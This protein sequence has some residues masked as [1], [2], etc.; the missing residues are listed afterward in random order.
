VSATEPRK[1]LTH[2]HRLSQGQS[3]KC[4]STR[5]HNRGSLGKCLCDLL[6]CIGIMICLS[7]IC[8]LWFGR[9]SQV[10]VYRQALTDVNGRR[11]TT[12]IGCRY[13]WFALCD[14]AEIAKSRNINQLMHTDANGERSTT[15]IGCKYLWFAL[16]DLADIAKS[17]NNDQFTPVEG[18]PLILGAEGLRFVLC[19]W[20]EVVKLLSYMLVSSH[21]V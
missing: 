8:L 7:A 10:T 20:D 14:L 4:W 16:C 6:L 13:L 3:Y 18:A 11:S 21:L 17:L 2:T 15:Y 9:D 5:Q 12:S 19:D 1:N